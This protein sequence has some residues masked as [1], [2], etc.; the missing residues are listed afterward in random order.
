MKN[1]KPL[2]SN[3]EQLRQALERHD[4]YTTSDGRVFSGEF[5]EDEGIA[6]HIIGL[7]YDVLLA[8]RKRRMGE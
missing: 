4:R 7:E 2:F 6:R 8:E 5:L 3:D 1:D